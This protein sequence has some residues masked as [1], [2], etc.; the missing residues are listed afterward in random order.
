V[1]GEV[2]ESFCVPVV[3]FEA[4]SSWDSLWVTCGALELAR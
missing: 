4:L 2:L 3:T 1:D